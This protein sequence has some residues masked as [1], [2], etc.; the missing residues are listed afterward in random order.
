MKHNFP[1]LLFKCANARIDRRVLLHNEHE[2]RINIAGILHLLVSTFWNG[3]VGRSF[4]IQQLNLSPIY[5][6][7]AIK[8]LKNVPISAT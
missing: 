8:L 3:I 4:K 6:S 7:V 5:P 1:F 2:I